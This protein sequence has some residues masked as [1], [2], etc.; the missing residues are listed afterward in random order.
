LIDFPPRAR[1][2]SEQIQ[3]KDF[4]RISLASRTCRAQTNDKSCP[5]TRS[6][7]SSSSFS[8]AEVAPFG[9]RDDRLNL[10]A[11]QSQQMDVYV[12]SGR[13]SSIAEFFYPNFDFS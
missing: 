10:H 6:I 12:L 4:R 3:S 5:S 11:F 8:A 9:H 7:S 1:I 2:G 13:K